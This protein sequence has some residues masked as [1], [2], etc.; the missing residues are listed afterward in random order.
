M[1]PSPPAPD[2]PVRLR[3]GDNLYANA[4]VDVDVRTGKGRWHRQLGPVEW[5]ASRTVFTA[6]SIRR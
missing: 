5:S 6:L 2:L 1:R 3:K 4:V